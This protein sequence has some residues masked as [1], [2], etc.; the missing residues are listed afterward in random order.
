M[1][2][3]NEGRKRLVVLFWHTKTKRFLFFLVDDDSDTGHMMN[4]GRFLGEKATKKTSLHTELAPRGGVDPRQ[5]SFLMR[6]MT[7]CSQSSR[8]RRLRPLS[9]LVTCFAF[10]TPKKRGEAGRVAWL[11]SFPQQKELG[12]NN[13]KYE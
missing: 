3:S 1:R 5:L 8:A 9:G 10:C 4:I 6:E 7:M 12:Q 2:K 11:R 13:N